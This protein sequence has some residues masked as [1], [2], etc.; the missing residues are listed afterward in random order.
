MKPT[1]VSKYP[2]REEV[3]K[4]GSDPERV[5]AI[6]SFWL[7]LDLLSKPLSKDI[8]EQSFCQGVVRDFQDLFCQEIQR[9]MIDLFRFRLHNIYLVMSSG[10]LGQGTVKTT[11]P[12]TMLAFMIMKKMPKITEASYMYAILENIFLIDLATERRLNP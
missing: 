12:R 1:K 5:V 4:R 3:H 6:D 7:Q 8:L 9:S 10:G 2:G 11:I